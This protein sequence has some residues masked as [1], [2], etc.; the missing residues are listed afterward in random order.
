MEK[1]K[2][3]FCRLFLMFLLVLG[4]SC[5]AAVPSGT[6]NA[7]SMK[8]HKLSGGSFQEIGSQW[9]YTYQDGSHPGKGLY[10]TDGKT[11][12]LN[13]N[14]R[15]H[16]GWQTISGSR[17]YFGKRSEGYLY[18]K[19]W[20][21]DKSGNVYRLNKNGTM[22]TGLKKVGKNYYY[23]D[24]DTG[25]RQSGWQEIDG[26]TYY[27]RKNGKACRTTLTKKGV[28]YSFD[29]TTGELL[30]TN[31]DITGISS[32]CD[33]L[34]NADTG[35]VLYDKNGSV[36]HANAS[37]TKILTCILALENSSLTDVVTA[38]ANAAAQE[39]TKIYMREGEKFYMKDLLYGLMLPSGNDA[40]V[41]IAEH[42]SGS[43]SAFAKL[44]NQKAKEIGCT[45][46]HFV[47]PN[48]LDAGYNHYTT[49][50][51]L[52]KI[53][54]YAYQNRAF[55][56]IVKTKSYSFKSISGYSYQL[57]TTN[58]LLGSMTGVAGIKTGYTSKA[59]YCFVGAI[60]SKNG[61]TY[62]SVVLGAPTS[63][64]RWS[65]SRTL[66]SYAYRL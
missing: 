17:Y 26:K 25:I 12:Y 38:S 64:V 45:S 7:A 50:L 44:M 4:L 51:D 62:I 32:D 22:A 54:R 53:A 36:K 58:E 34:I 24:P 2:S 41:A 18:Q 16:Y 15:R 31:A 19:C 56:S 42:I 66:L 52:A 47:T 20:Y 13:K 37:T 21:T 59:G 61:G 11:Y 29:S 35:V 46:T 49:A 65:D 6:A 14:G 1:S 5:A 9:Y 63:A 60:V 27:F 33:V 28:T 43:T 23:F 8:V 39:P 57:T 30:S 10:Q 48:G 40:A 3:V 55:R